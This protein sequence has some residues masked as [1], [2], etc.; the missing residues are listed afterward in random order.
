M[1]DRALP[2]LSARDWVRFTTACDEQPAHC[3][4]AFC[5]AFVRS[6]VAAFETGATDEVSVAV[7]AAMA[8]DAAEQAAKLV[9][10]N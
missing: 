1:K 7:A 4:E 5:S 9:R 10:L 2:L 8:L 6:L 3:R